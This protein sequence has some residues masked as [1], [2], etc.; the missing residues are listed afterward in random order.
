[1]SKGKENKSS[2]KSTSSLCYKNSY[3]VRAPSRSPCGY[4]ALLGVIILKLSHFF[5]GVECPHGVLLL[6]SFFGNSRAARFPHA[7]KVSMATPTGGEEVVVHHCK[8][9]RNLRKGMTGTMGLGEHPWTHLVC[10]EQKAFA[11][12]PFHL[13]PPGRGLVFSC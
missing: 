2:K 6:E 7:G 5:S 4:S 12:L 11:N 10:P 13:S 8:W 1:M 9:R 3:S